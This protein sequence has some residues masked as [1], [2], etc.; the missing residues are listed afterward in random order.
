MQELTIQLSNKN[1]RVLEQLVK[2]GKFKTV[3][4]ALGD[5]VNNYLSVLKQN[6]PSDIV[7]DLQPA[8]GRAIKTQKQW[9]AYFNQLKQIMI[10]A[11]IIYQAS[12]TASYEILQSLRQDFIDDM[13][14]S[15]TRI[16]YNPDNL[17]AR[18]TH[19]FGSSVTQPKQIDVAEV[20]IYKRESAKNVVGDNKNPGKG[21]LY[22][23]ALFDTQDR[24]NTILNTLEKLSQRASENIMFWTPDQDSRRAYSERVADFNYHFRRQFIVDSDN[25]FDNSEGLSRKVFENPRS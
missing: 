22:V 5:A 2:S 21:L 4:S 10:S 7:I 8:D 11:P 25:L 3:D 18:I 1:A 14:T 23:R 17:G 6:Q 24:P 15:S 9:I 19:N 20:P 12:K 16:S 13:I